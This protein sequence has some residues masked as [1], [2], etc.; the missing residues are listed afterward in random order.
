M[1]NGLE[2]ITLK[3]FLA[4]EGLSE[5]LQDIFLRFAFHSLK[6]QDTFPKYLKGTQNDLNKY[7]EVVAELDRWANQSLLSYIATNKEVNTIYSEEIEQPYI[8]NPYGNYFITLDPLDGSSNIISNN[9]FGIILGIYNKKLPQ[10]GNKLLLSAI[11]VYG[12]VNTLIYSSGNGTHEFVKHYDKD[13]SAEFYLL[14]KNLKFP[15][16][17][18]VFGIGGHP[19]DWEEKFLVF[20]KELFKKEK[21]KV[22]YC[23]ALVGDFSQILHRGGFFAYPST[24]KNKEGKLRITY[25]C[26]PVAFLAVNA[27]GAAVDGKQSILEKEVINVDERTPFYVGNKYL[28]EKLIKV[29]NE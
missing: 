23:G 26:N 12:P 20:A 11:K 13:G 2:N 25:E 8:V 14:H 6:M 7:G 21:L 24:K 10:K 19:L 17:G 15:E 27:N 16:P 18:E 4:K 3:E 1:G 22:R 5:Q 28:I 9:I 29:L